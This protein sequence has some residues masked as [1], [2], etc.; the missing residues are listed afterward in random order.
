MHGARLVAFPWNARSSVNQP[1]WVATRARQRLWGD[2]NDFSSLCLS[3][4]LFRFGKQCKC[5]CARM[6]FCVQIA[7]L[8]K[9]N[10][11]ITA[12]TYLPVRFCRR[13]RQLVL[14]IWFSFSLLFLFDFHF[15]FECTFI[16]T[17]GG[18][19]TIAYFF[20][21]KPPSYTYF[22]MYIFKILT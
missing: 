16:C 6:D 17:I 3:S 15:I 14:E 11:G 20:L 13:G 12:P 18:N 2:K 21:S 8:K 19:M 9:T 4:F 7:L 5:I 22:L 10:E 1:Q